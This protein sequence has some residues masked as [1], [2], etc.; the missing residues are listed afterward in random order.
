[1]TVTL[2]NP[3]PALKPVLSS[4]WALRPAQV[5]CCAW[6]ALFFL[7]VS[8]I[9]LFHTDIWGH[10]LF[11]QVILDQH[12]LPAEDPFLPLAEGMPLVDGAWLSQVIFA[13]AVRAYGPEGLS[14]VF[15]VTVLL[16]HLVLA[17][18]FFLQTKSIALSLLGSALVVIISWSRHAII[19]PEIFGALCFAILLWMIVRS[20]AES[21]VDPDGTTRSNWLA[22]WIGLPLLFIL[23][24][25]LHGSFPVGVIVLGCY[26]L[27]RCIEVAWRTRDFWAVVQDADVRRWVV[28]TE[29]AAAATLVNPYGTELIAYTFRF[30]NNANLKDVL[31]WFPLKLVD[32]EGWLV[33]FSVVL[34]M[35]VLRHSRRAV[36]PVEV[37]LWASMMW[38]LA[39]AARMINWYAFALMVVL[40]PHMADVLRRLVDA[41]TQGDPGAWKLFRTSQDQKRSFTLSLVA[42]L[43]VWSAFAFSPLSFPVLGGKPRDP[44]TVHSRQTPLAL[45]QYL[46]KNPPRNLVFTPQWWG[47][48]LCWSGP[49]GMKVFMTTN[50]HLV[51]ATVWNDYLRLSAGRPAGMSFSNATT[52]RRW[53]STRIWR[54]GWRRASIGWPVGPSRTRMIWRC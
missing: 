52:C 28:W 14:M 15:A 6:F 21:R 7:Y 37:L 47:D 32:F 49:P 10:V 39:G 43:M 1:M 33:G 2:E 12:A 53:S 36:R 45:S 50:L 11:G 30:G 27:G 38:M 51:P 23:W 18:T 25:N 54:V 26:A 44:R 16:T 34:V 17:R 13:A 19:R 22:T 31:E 20:D 3:Q 35:I 8:F 4:R 46:R 29:I 41:Q 9:P 5:V 48:W 40:M 24:T 42:V